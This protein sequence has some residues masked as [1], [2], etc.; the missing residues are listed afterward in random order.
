MSIPFECCVLSRRGLCVGLITRPEES[1]RCGVSECDSEDNEETLAH[2]ALL[3]HGG[4][5]KYPKQYLQKYT[6]REIR[7][8]LYLVHIFT[9]V[10]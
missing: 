1:Y 2:W 3:R 9:N 4:K 7:R 6:L 5:K 8:V 10:L